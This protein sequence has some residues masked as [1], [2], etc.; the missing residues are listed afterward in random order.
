MRNRLGANRFA[1]ARKAGEVESESQSGGVPLA[2]APAR[3]DERVIANLRKR[4]VKRAPGG[5]R[6]DHIG[7]GPLR[8]DGLDA[9]SACA[10][11]QKSEQRRGHEESI[12]V[13][14]R[15]ESTCGPIRPS[16]RSPKRGRAP[17]L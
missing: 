15:P 7:E 11:G 12:V 17:S 16:R 8:D 13:D 5:G 14:F 3:E 1:G 6:E 10:A 2:K 4:L 9:A